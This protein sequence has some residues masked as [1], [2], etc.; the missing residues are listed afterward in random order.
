[1]KKPD[2]ILDEIHATRHKINEKTKAMS[3]TENTAYF[4]STGERLAK[5]Y[6]LKRVIVDEV[7]GYSRV[8]T[9]KLLPQSVYIYIPVSNFDKSEKWYADM[10]GFTTTL[11][12]KLYRDMSLPSG[13]RIMLIEQLN[14]VNS[15]MLFGGMKQAA[16]GFTVDN[17]DAI[18]EKLISENVII[19]DINEYQGKSFNFTDPDG[20]V[21]ELWQE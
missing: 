13:V 7:R 2:T 8:V 4:S 11:C 5:R 12:N 17:L 16:Y 9:R 21:I 20:N 14:D 15:H 18:R 1:M 19:G 3:T 6:G 10:F